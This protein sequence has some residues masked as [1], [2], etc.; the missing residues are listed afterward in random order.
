[1][2]SDDL[3][4]E[5]E[6]GLPADF[7]AN[8]GK[9]LALLPYDASPE[10]LEGWTVKDW[11]TSKQVPVRYYER[12]AVQEPNKWSSEK[13][14]QMQAALYQLGLYGPNGRYTV[15]TWDLADQKAYTKLLMAA[16]ISGRTAREQLDE[17]HIRPPDLATVLG[18]QK[19]S[20]HLTNPADIRKSARDVSKNLLGKVDRS[21]VEAAP[22]A[23][24]GEQLAAGEATLGGASVVTDEGSM[25]GS[26]EERLRREKPIEV[27]GHSFVNQY[28]NFIKLLGPVV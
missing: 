14:V 13:L 27:D 28:Q 11:N 5:A 7:L 8:G 10:A 15:G 17:W 9:G 3:A 20:V 18:D 2:S 12:D 22:A 16:N 1:M 24:Q 26:L 19:G 6:G 23:Y 4:A 25:V 21:F